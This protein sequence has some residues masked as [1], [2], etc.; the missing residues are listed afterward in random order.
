MK[1][2]VKKDQSYFTYNWL[3][4]RPNFCRE[5]RDSELIGRRRIRLNAAE[6]TLCLMGP[7]CLGGTFHGDIMLS[8]TFFRILKL[9][10]V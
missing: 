8:S 4:T 2:L 10:K 3:I 6:S 9:L 1:P 7:T 5:L